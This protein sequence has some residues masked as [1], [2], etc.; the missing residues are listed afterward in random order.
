MNQFCKYFLCAF[1]FLCSAQQISAQKNNNAEI[2]YHVFQ[3][4]F[5]DSNGDRIGDLNGLRQKL[6][7][8]QNLGVTSILLLPLYQSVYYHNYFSSDFYKIDQSFGTMK[9]Y[10]ALV[11]DIH[12][13]GMKVYMDME[14]QYVTEDHRWYKD[15]Y[16]NPK[17]KY[18]KY[19]L[20]RDSANNEPS[21][22]V[23][24]LKGLKGYNGVYRRIT[25][26][27]LRNPEVL[28]YN[29]KLFK[30]W[31]DPNGDGKFDDGVDGFRLDHMMDHLDNK[32]QLDSLFTYFWTPL[33]ARLKN[34]NPSLIFI[35][36]QAEWGSYGFDYLRKGLV[37]RVFDFRLAFAVRNFNKK[38]IT[39]MADT[40]LNLYST[41]KH[42]VVFIENH[43]MPRFAWVVKKDLAKE[44][45]GAALN[46]LIGGVPSIYYGQEIGMTSSD[47]KK[48]NYGMNDASGIPDREA[49]EWYKSDSGKGMAFWYKNSGPWWTDSNDK[50]NDGISL[51]E[52]Q[53]D[54]ASL[55]NYYKALI[56]LRKSNEAISA[57]KYQT[58]Q[59][60]NQYVVSFARKTSTNYALVLINLSGSTQEAHISKANIISGKTS[61]KNIFGGINADVVQDDFSVSLPA[62]S[63]QVF[64]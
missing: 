39:K 27:N 49:F 53:N 14:T 7:Y 30:Y 43:D 19:L 60:D 55:F 64:E 45:V 63:V 26:V 56:R 52:E 47:P 46:L 1:L 16:R 62:Y 57:G 32:P 21:T 10:L 18:S 58:I 50:P 61:W 51:E 35:A 37:D 42:Q 28:E 22:I 34:I 9:D 38:E 44:K 33:I 23:M 5:Y 3:R 15:S 8:L 40:T 11:K 4:S 36:E 54:S 59:N 20:Y 31:E 12:R 29:Y 41:N 13:R 17:S 25:T 6:D 24:D 2:I 48:R